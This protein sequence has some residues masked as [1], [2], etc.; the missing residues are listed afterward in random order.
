MVGAAGRPQAVENRARAVLSAH[1]REPGF[2]CPNADRYPWMWLWDSC[3]HS[4]VW[5]VLGDADRATRELETVFIGQ[6]P[7]SGFVPH[8]GYF[9]E[10]TVASDFWGRPGFSSITQPPMFG[11]AI[12]ELTR[13]GIDVPEALV[14]RC[15]KGLRFLVARRRRSVDGLIELVHPWE[16]GADDCPRW[17]DLAGS[18]YSLAGWK[19]VKGSLLASIERTDSGA[20]IA[21]P[22]F[23]VASASFNALIA[24]NLMELASVTGDAWAT[25]AA[26]QLAE[27]LDAR[28]SA[29]LRTWSDSGPTER[30]SGRCR[31]SDAQLGALVSRRPA[32][33]TAVFD[34]LVDPE[35][36]GGSFGPTGVHRQEPTFDPGTYWR[37]P[38]WPQLGYL[39][40]LAANRNGRADVA[41]TLA[42]GLVRGAVT[43]GFAEY[44]HSDTGMGGGAVPQ[45]WTTL[46]LLMASDA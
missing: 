40:W 14:D 18:P 44:W 30:G 24:F 25:D 1:W 9:G 2:T 31:T 23:P 26:T 15:S 5:G 39:L 8:M 35:A 17:D 41:A 21:N 42:A 27:A 12:A 20:P 33:R 38:T 28:W 34:D 46:M 45:S 43:S 11:H 32:A 6:D 19:A 29:E 4:I 36:H 22:A 16:S 13:Q 37:G 7:V 10:P 3:F